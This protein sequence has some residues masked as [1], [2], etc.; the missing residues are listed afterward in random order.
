MPTHL[1]SSS[2]FIFDHSFFS[3]ELMIIEKADSYILLAIFLISNARERV[4]ANLSLTLYIC[5]IVLVI[6]YKQETRIC[7]STLQQSK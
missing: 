5:G 6:V 4:P 3:E 2:I 1:I 7:E